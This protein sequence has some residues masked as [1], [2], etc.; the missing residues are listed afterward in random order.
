M[1]HLPRVPTRA[2]RIANAVAGFEKASRE[3]HEINLS[4]LPR[5]LATQVKAARD[6]AGIGAT[7]SHEVL[8]MDRP[9]IQKNLGLAS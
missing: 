7:I 6:A 4:G 8:K 5:P 2:N 3:L 1:P 9:A